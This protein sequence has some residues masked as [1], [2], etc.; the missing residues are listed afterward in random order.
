MTGMEFAAVAAVFAA[1]ATTEIAAGDRC[2]IEC[3]SQRYPRSV[4]AWQLASKSAHVGQ[5]RLSRRQIRRNYA[6][7]RIMS[8]SLH[9][10][11]FRPCR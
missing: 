6:E 9:G 10:F 2:R 11:S 1:V 7:H 3:A 8:E 4:F 5:L